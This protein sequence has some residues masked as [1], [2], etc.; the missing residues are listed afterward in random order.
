M[1]KLDFLYAAALIPGHGKSKG[2]IMS[3]VIDFIDCETAD[4]VTLGCGVPLGPAFGRFD[5]CRIGSDVGPYW[6]DYLKYISYPERVS[7]ENSLTSTIGR[8]QLDRRMF[9]NDPDVFLLRNGVRGIN[10][11]RLNDYQRQ[12]LLLLNNLLGG[13][14][15]FSDQLSQLT[16]FQQ[17]QLRTSYPLLEPEVTGFD[18][19]NKLYHFEFRIE[20]KNYIVYANLSGKKR[21][22]KLPE[23]LWFNENLFLVKPGT[24]ILLEPYQSICFFRSNPDTGREAYLLG[25]SGHIFP[26]AQVSEIISVFEGL[27]IKLH[28]HASPDTIVYLAVPEGFSKYKVNGSHHD[29]LKCEEVNYIAISATAGQEVKK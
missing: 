11:N 10:E 25:A 28:E 24:N 1:L 3:E 14:L 15:F 13:L 23:G 16:S 18:S 20:G 2:E 21:T 7:A 29:V 17:R 8:R 26:G 9:R 4:S 6:E 12:T 27:I 22:V 5:Y 19:Y